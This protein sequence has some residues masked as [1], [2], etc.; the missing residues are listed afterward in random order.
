[1]TTATATHIH[2]GFYTVIT[3]NTHRTFRIHTQPKDASFA[4]GKQVIGYLHGPDNGRDYR[5]FGFIQGGKL[6]PWKRFQASY[7]LLAVARFLL[8]SDGTEA[9][10]EYAKQSGNCYVCNRLLTTPES[11][12]AG[13]GPTCASRI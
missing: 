13:I 9:G 10:K 8:E 4:P 1:M 3:G 2:N 11:I 5:G 7:D 12:A 6:V